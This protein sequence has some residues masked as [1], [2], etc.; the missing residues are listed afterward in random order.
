VRNLLRFVAVNAIAGVIGAIAVESIKGSVSSDNPARETVLLAIWPLAIIA[1]LIAFVVWVVRGDHIPPAPPPPAGTSPISDSTT[2]ILQER[3]AELSDQNAGLQARLFEAAAQIKQLE[4]DVLSQRETVRALS[5]RPPSPNPP[6]WLPNPMDLSTLNIDA[7][8]L[9]DCLARA[10]AEA[11]SLLAPDAEFEFREFRL[12]APVRIAF[13]A[14]SRQATRN[15]W[16]FVAENFE[17]AS[18]PKRGSGRYRFDNDTGRE[19]DLWPDKAEP[20]PW[21]S[22]DSWSTLVRQVGYQTRPLHAGSITLRYTDS[23]RLCITPPDYEDE[24]TGEHDTCYALVGDRAE[25]VKRPGAV[26]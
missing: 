21:V 5:S 12:A 16:I 22:D 23:W 26:T 3:I 20:P 6:K 2:K 25:I 1:A 4:I 19:V 17:T 14:W 9:D 8:D 24:L 18:K 13:H 7:E 15:V 11:V 10:K